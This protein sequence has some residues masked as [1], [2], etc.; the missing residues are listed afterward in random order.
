ME[1]TDCGTLSHGVTSIETMASA[2]SCFGMHANHC[3]AEDYLS[4]RFQQSVDRNRFLAAAQFL[5][6]PHIFWIKYIG[7][8]AMSQF[9][10]SD[11]ISLGQSSLNIHGTSRITFFLA[12][13]G[14]NVAEQSRGG[15]GVLGKSLSDFP[16]RVGE[17]LQVVV[18]GEQEVASGMN[19][20]EI[21]IAAKPQRRAMNKPNVLSFCKLLGQGRIG[22]SL[23]RD[24]V[25]H[26]LLWRV[27][28]SAGALQAL[29]AEGADQHFQRWQRVIHKAKIRLF[30]RS[31]NNRHVLT[32]RAREINKC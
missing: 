2:C 1:N 29:R 19:D 22:S 23:E 10:R 26:P 24:C 5:P 6:H 27:R 13:I 30:G 3:V 9:K 12:T 14:Q 32:H 15:I 17:V 11:V 31:R 4:S 25:D 18:G 20:G 21:A 7:G 16:E 8:S 28:D